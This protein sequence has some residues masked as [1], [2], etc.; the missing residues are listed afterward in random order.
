MII[1]F[2]S[3]GAVHVFQRNRHSVFDSHGR[4]LI[5]NNP[6]DVVPIDVIVT[7]EM[8]FAQATVAAPGGRSTPIQVVTSDGRVVRGSGLQ[9][10]QPIAAR[11]RW[12]RVRRIARSI[13]TSGVWSGRVNRYEISRFSFDGTEQVRLVR[14]APWFKPYEDIIP[15]E[16]WSTPDR[17]SRESSSHGMGTF[18]AQWL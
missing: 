17:N 1:R 4:R 6:M 3:T 11:N 9:P 5:S 2:D 16:G 18:G 14:E 13:A 10:D 7:E 15:G 12:D 8:I